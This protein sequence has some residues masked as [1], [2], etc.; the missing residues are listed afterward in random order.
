M[1]SKITAY[2]LITFLIRLAVILWLW[3]WHVVKILHV[4][5]ITFGQAFGLMTLAVWACYSTPRDYWNDA[6]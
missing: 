6:D 2:C 5:E 1:V 3:N 4:P